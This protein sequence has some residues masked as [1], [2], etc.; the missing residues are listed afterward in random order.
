MSIFPRKNNCARIMCTLYKVLRK[1][2]IKTNAKVHGNAKPAKLYSSRDAWSLLKREEMQTQITQTSGGIYKREKKA[3]RSSCSTASH[4]KPREEK[5]HVVWAG[6]YFRNES[7][8]FLPP[9]PFFRSG[10]TNARFSIFADPRNS[11]R[12]PRTTILG[13]ISC[14]ERKSYIVTIRLMSLF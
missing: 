1:K 8:R 11:I 5:G 3:T 6:I 2:M 13:N 4:Y 12:R 10:K 14:N 9:F 7:G